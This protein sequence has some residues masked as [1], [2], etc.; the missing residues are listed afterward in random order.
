[1]ANKPVPASTGYFNKKMLSI[2]EGDTKKPVK[3]PEKTAKKSK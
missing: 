2:L 1:M 3:K